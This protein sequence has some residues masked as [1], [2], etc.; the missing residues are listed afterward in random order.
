MCSLHGSH[1]H[2]QPS[3]TCGAG[4]LEGSS[5]WGKDNRA[6]C[7]DCMRV[8]C[9]SCQEQGIYPPSNMIA[10]LCKKGGGVDSKAEKCC[11]ITEQLQKS[12][13]LT[14]MLTR[15][16]S[17]AFSPALN[18]PSGPLLVADVDYIEV[19]RPG[20]TLTCS[21]SLRGRQDKDL[22][23]SSYTRETAFACPMTPFRMDQILIIRG[24]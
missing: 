21:S 3:N 4:R 15:E 7:V 5:N 14:L 16:M 18:C 22:K 13:V 19:L 2:S 1:W 8:A 20:V 17:N 6:V 12:S 10:R 23:F 24:G 11:E 9:G